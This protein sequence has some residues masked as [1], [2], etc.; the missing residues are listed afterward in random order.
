MLGLTKPP[1][2][3]W[4][5]M[6]WY[7]HETQK[8][9]DRGDILISIEVLPKD[10]ATRFDN[11]LGRSEPNM[12]P[13]LPPPTGRFKFHML[14]NPFYVMSECLG[15]ALYGRACACVGLI[16]I[17]VIAIFGMPYISA[18]VTIGMAVF[19]LSPVL[20][21]VLIALLAVCLVS[22]CSWCGFNY[23]YAVQL[24][25]TNTEGSYDMDVD[26]SRKS[27]SMGSAKKA[28]PMDRV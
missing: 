8:R 2:A 24:A 1:N 6:T 27:V 11:G 22:V 4:L 17:V 7:N 13:R 23:C 19:T 3:E 10:I 28:D 9:E 12:H 26:H 14:W 18:F 21:Y 15:P 5:N 20:T 16:L 25:V